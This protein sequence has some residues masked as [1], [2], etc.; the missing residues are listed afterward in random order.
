MRC[1]KQRRLYRRS[2]G[3]RLN[4][5]S[6]VCIL[7]MC[8]WQPRV[9]PRRQSIVAPPVGDSDRGVAAD[10]LYETWA[11]RV[12]TGVVFYSRG[13]GAYRR[14]VTSASHARDT[15][16]ADDKTCA[17]VEVFKYCCRRNAN[18]TYVRQLY[19]DFID[20]SSTIA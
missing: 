15:R 20:R 13:N 6:I 12:Q 4:I 3:C 18:R 9:Q 14:L 7:T 1:K 10:A 17:R 8:E 19:A 5:G 16:V 11:Y 2:L